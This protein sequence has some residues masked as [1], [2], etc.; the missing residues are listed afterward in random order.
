M[1]VA[2]CVAVAVVLAGCSAIS[3]FDFTFSDSDAG[4]PADG[5]PDAGGARDAGPD[6][7][8]TDA[9]GPLDAGPGG[10]PSPCEGDAVADF[11]RTGAPLDWRYH[12]DDLSPAG[13]S[14]PELTMGDVRLG[15]DTLNGFAF[16]DDVPLIAR[17]ADNAAAAPCAGIAGYLL[18]ASDPDDTGRG[19]P[20]L[21]FEAGS[22]GGVRVQGRL[23]SPDGMVSGE[24]Y[25]VFVSRNARPD[26]ASSVEIVPGTTPTEFDL[27]VDTLMGDRVL[28]TVEQTS[29]PTAAPVGLQAWVTRAGAPT[30]DRCQI[31]L[32]FDGT[33]P[34]DDRCQ[35]FTVENRVDGIGPATQLSR[36]APGANSW[37]GTSQELFELGQWLRASPAPVDHSGDWTL[38]LWA[39][40]STDSRFDHSL[41]ADSSFDTPPGGISIWLD[42]SQAWARVHHTRDS[43]TCNDAGRPDVCVVFTALGPV[44]Y[45]EWHYYR[46]VRRAADNEIVLCVD[47]VQ[48]GRLAVSGALDLTGPYRPSLGRNVDFNPAYYQGRLDDL[49][50]YDA[51]LPCEL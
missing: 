13:L 25:R 5:G 39:N 24:T 32:R 22:D 30:L 43:S 27:P 1:R 15:G 50:I 19:H 38:S 51:A 31:G 36:S 4:E 45:G 41:Y 48:R 21:S 28:I 3:R 40:A 16:N 7:G 20:T 11:G 12:R 9:G 17:C 8:A 42:G 34:L 6:A 29:G 49:R 23:R 26:I 44:S 35:R 18:V 37:L 10:C 47:G 33:T 46:A 2:A 14:Y